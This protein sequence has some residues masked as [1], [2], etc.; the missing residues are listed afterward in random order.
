MKKVTL[1]EGQKKKLKIGAALVASIAGG[2]FMIRMIS[3]TK[4]GED[5][6]FKVAEHLMKSI[7]EKN[8]YVVCYVAANNPAVIPNEIMTA[9]DK[10]VYTYA[11]PILEGL[12]K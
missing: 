9:I 8:G 11:D 10:A 5:I 3:G 7:I 2:Y 6:K 12:K 4:V 1:T